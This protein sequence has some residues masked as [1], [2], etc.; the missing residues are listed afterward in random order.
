MVLP[1]IGLV[2]VVLVLYVALFVVAFSMM[3]EPPG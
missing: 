2:G 1:Q 3:K